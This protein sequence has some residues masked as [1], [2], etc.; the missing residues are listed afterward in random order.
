MVQLEIGCRPLA[1]RG[2][3]RITK[4]G[5]QRPY[6]SHGYCCAITKMQPLLLC[7][8]QMLPACDGTNAWLVN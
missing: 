7:V 1:R 4:R 2:G 5:R 3:L 6:Q 8:V